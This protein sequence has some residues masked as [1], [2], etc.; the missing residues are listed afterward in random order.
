MNKSI[1]T[2]FGGT[3]VGAISVAVFLQASTSSPLRDTSS[4]SAIEI[5]SALQYDRSTLDE[6]IHR[7][8]DVAATLTSV[9]TSLQETTERLASISTAPTQVVRTSTPVIPDYPMNSPGVQSQPP[10]PSEPGPPTSEQVELYT[11]IQEKLYNA[12]NNH[13][14]VL[15][16]LIQNANDLT[17]EQRNEL[18]REAMGMIERGELK[19]EQFT[20][21]PD[22]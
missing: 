16:K 6:Q 15:S 20:F 4:L 2:F 14:V 19:V 21:R 5:P 22:S 1:L 8:G 18:T 11:S 10:G 12:T 3:A 7:V 17:P 9:A 13:S